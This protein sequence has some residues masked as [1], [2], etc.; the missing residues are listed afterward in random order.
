MR[1]YSKE[2]GCE[3]CSRS[4]FQMTLSS[5]LKNAS[6]HLLIQALASL[7]YK[8]LKH[9]MRITFY[10]AFFH[11]R[12]CVFISMKH[13]NANA[14]EV[15]RQNPLFFY[16]LLLFKTQLDIELWHCPTSWIL[17]LTF[18]FDALTRKLLTTFWNVHLNQLG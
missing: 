13:D 5:Q 4:K 6:H 9:F 8:K 18:S 15:M 16:F 3:I 1:L 17:D 10:C 12:L 11:C 14:A 2:A 7:E